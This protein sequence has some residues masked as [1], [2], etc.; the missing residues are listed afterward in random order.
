MSR[1]IKL[2]QM[3]SEV[4]CREIGDFIVEK[5]IAVRKTGGV[6]GLSGGVDSSTTAGLAK[7]GYE[8]YNAK[9]PKVPLELVGYILPSK[10]N[11]SKDTEDGIMVA[12]KL[13]IRYEVVNLEN[14]VQAFK[15]TN[16]EVFETKYDKGNMISRIRAVVLNTKAATENKLVLGTGNKDEDFG[17][18]YYT[19]FGDGAVH[20]SPIGGLSKRLVRQMA[21]Y[22]K[23][24]KDIVDREP[25]AG[26]ELGQTDFKDLGYY[27]DVVE[28]VSEG[29]SQG[30]SPEELIADS[31][32][33]KL[34]KKQ[35]AMQEKPKFAAVE[36]VVYDILARNKGAAAKAEILHPPAA[37][38]TLYYRGDKNE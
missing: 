7:S 20:I 34:V 24:G 22:L 2:P 5:T 9:M 4:A 3:D 19:L 16:P 18:G 35:I 28:I 12:E 31:D 33:S 6:V 37:P 14:A 11:S 26:L 10:I 1:K 30:L 36:G 32:I 17:I 15:S 21:S 23:F 25:T 38:V 8:I 27:Y 13:K 29:I